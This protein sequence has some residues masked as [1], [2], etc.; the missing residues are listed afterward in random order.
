MDKYREGAHI[1][2]AFQNWS[3]LGN[4]DQKVPRITGEQISAR[5]A[6]LPVPV[7]RKSAKCG[8]AATNH[9]TDLASTECKVSIGHYCGGVSVLGYKF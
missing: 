4:D 7:M 1:F 9:A 6:N 2:V 3:T 8:S 5:L